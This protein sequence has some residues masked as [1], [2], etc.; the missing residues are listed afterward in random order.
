MHYY[1]NSFKEDI[2]KTK[3]AQ[4]LFNLSEDI[5]RL[6]YHIVFLQV[7][8]A[9]SIIPDGF[10]VN[11]NPCIGKPRKKFISDWEGELVNVESKLRDLVLYAYAEN[12][13]KSE[14]T[15]NCL[16]E[17]LLIQDFVIGLRNIKAPTVNLRTKNKFPK[18]L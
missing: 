15:F 5:Y 10:T 17:E 13:F 3:L 9:Y 1:N 18:K 6:F 7:C 12:L 14:E 2:K 11:E 4:Q 16:F 8:S